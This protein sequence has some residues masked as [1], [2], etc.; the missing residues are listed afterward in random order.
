MK[1]ESRTSTV[2][3]FIAL[4]TMLVLYISWGTS[5][6]TMPTSSAEQQRDMAALKKQ[7]AG[8]QERVNWLEERLVE[9]RR[10]RELP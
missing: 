6:P 3:L 2:V 5:Q 9:P 8:L 7:I 1:T 4:A 10:H